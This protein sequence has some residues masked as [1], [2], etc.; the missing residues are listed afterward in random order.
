MS[1]TE[2]DDF[3][4]IKN[5]IEDLKG[6]QEV[7]VVKRGGE[8][9]IF[10][11][12]DELRKYKNENPGAFDVISYGMDIEI[13]LEIKVPVSM[14][15]QIDVKYGMVEVVNFNALLIAMATCG[16]VDVS[17]NETMVGQVVAETNYGQI[18]SNLKSQFTGDKH[19]RDF[20]TM[21]SAQ[22]GTGPKYQVESTYGNV[23]LRRSP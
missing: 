18:Y 21:V 14:T 23:Y 5:K 15:T 20:H 13:E 10:R 1:I 8:K 12:R 17:L 4:S 11:S 22:L 6:T 9:F 3:I 2:G 16:G 7:I 19:E